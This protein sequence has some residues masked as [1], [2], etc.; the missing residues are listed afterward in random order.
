MQIIIIGGGGVGYEVARNL[1]E[2]HQDVVV[3]EKNEVKARRFSESLDVMIIQD[4]GANAAVLERAGIKTADMVIA[5]TQVDE[6][7]IIAC[8]L[9]KQYDVPITVCR[10]RNSGYAD[11]SS[12]LTPKQL[13]IDIVINPERVAAMEI[14]KMLH[15]PDASE[16]E[17]FNRGKVMML[18]V[19][20]GP[21]ADITGVPLY[22]LPLGPDCIVVGISEQDGKF[23][24]PGGKDVIRP[25]NK[26]YLLGDT[27]TLKDTSSLLHHEQTRVNQVT[28][29]GGGMIAYQ[30]ARLLEESKQPF[31]VKLIEK[32]ESRCEGL[33]RDLK[34]TLVL[35]GD[36]N[37]IAMLKEEDTDQAD[38]VI[39][40][41][42]DDRSN[43]V[44]ALLARQFGVKK[45]ICEVMKPQYVPVYNTLGIDSLINPRL[46][47]AAQI[48]RLTRR[49]DV[50]ALS[51]LQGEKAEVFEIIL[52]ETARAAGRRIAEI[53]LPRGMLIGSVVRN[54]DVFVP[55]GNTVL[56][57]DD[58]LVIFAVP[59]VSAKLDRY[60]APNDG[61]ESR[62]ALRN[63]I[64]QL[65]EET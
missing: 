58:H 13:G 14:S 40:A 45:I 36:T 27:R 35:Q 50:V 25:G 22:K 6:V 53:G 28:I 8:M 52:P 20:V 31:N 63:K 42:G 41:T 46:M 60:F 2:K 12:V 23:V 18:G 32:D 19:V 44:G 1:S 59:K 10:I 37:E 62:E 24:I 54:E 55:N 5:V 33:C 3:I 43:I 61:G 56:Y 57:P 49:E 26:I 51:I 9:A 29:L 30:L 34:K 15:F 65:I 7:N 17:Y 39:T 38:A 16:V 48:I 64:N 47:A 21:E 11:G 4:N